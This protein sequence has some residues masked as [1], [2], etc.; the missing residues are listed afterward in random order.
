MEDVQESDDEAGM[1]NDK[2][3]EIADISSVLSLECGV[4]EMLE[5][6]DGTVNSGEDDFTELVNEIDSDSGELDVLN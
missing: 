2:I 5:V 6:L 3:E 4:A 1:D